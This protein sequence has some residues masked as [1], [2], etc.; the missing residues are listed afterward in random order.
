MNTIHKYQT[1]LCLFSYYTKFNY[2]IAICNCYDEFAGLSDPTCS[3]NSF[4]VIGFL[5]VK[6][7]GLL[8]FSWLVELVREDCV[9]EL[10]VVKPRAIPDEIA[11]DSLSCVC[12]TVNKGSLSYKSA[13]ITLAFCILIEKG[14]VF[15]NR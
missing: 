6:V 5:C 2:E 12:V 11:F 13:K 8:G 7:Y 1:P 10:V 15:T 3:V 14:Q 4:G 9:V